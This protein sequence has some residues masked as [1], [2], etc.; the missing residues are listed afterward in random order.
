MDIL[1]TRKHKTQSVI[2]A[3]QNNAIL[4]FLVTFVCIVS[5]TA[6]GAVTKTVS[7]VEEPADTVVVITTTAVKETMTTEETTTTEDTTTTNDIATTEEITTTKEITATVEIMT[8]EETTI[9]VTT[10]TTTA[11]TPNSTGDTVDIGNW[12]ITFD[13]YEI[14][15]SIKAKFG[16]FVPDEG[17]MYFIAYL[18]VSNRGKNADTFL[19]SFSV[20]TDIRM[21]AIYEGEYEFSSTNLLAHDEDLHDKMLNPLSSKSGIVAFSM[22]EEVVDSPESLVIRFILHKDSVDFSL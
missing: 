16:S 11:Q 1:T 7:L 6:C 2:H 18:T 15:D 17:N 4:C 22:P 5:L 14:S 19:Q 21:K 20:N 3:L 10:P 13:S 9:A 8:T 12:R